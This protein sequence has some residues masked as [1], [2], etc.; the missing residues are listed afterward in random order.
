MRCRVWVFCTI[1]DTDW[2]NRTKKQPNLKTIDR[3]HACAQFNLG[4]SF[5]VAREWWTKA[6]AQGHELAIENLKRLDKREGKTAP[7]TTPPAPLLCSN[8][9]TRLNIATNNA[10]EN[11]GAKVVTTNNVKK[12]VKNNKR[13]NHNPNK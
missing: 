7:T 12:N 4:A 6:A 13:Q 1:M 9:A 5:E 8:N 11:I 2:I 3:G 10:K